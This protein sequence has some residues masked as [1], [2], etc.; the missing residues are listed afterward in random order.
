MNKDQELRLNALNT[1]EATLHRIKEEL[2]EAGYDERSA[3]FEKSFTSKLL[4]EYNVTLIENEKLKEDV[5]NLKNQ[6]FNSLKK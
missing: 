2:T 3:E 1:S 4:I 5:K 6:I